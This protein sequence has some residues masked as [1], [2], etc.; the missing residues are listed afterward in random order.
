M[1]KQTREL[2]SERTIKQAKEQAKEQA[3][4]C[5]VK[6]DYCHQQ[7]GESAIH[8]VPGGRAKANPGQEKFD[9]V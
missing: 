6:D 3:R 9:G 4:D 5:K 8:C 1:R 2:A 7:I